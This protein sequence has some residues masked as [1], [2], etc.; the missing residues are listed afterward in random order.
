MWK[1][2]PATKMNVRGKK[3]KKKKREREKR[4]EKTNPIVTKHYKNAKPRRL[5]LKLPKDVKPSLRLPL[6]LLN[7]AFHGL[8]STFRSRPC[9][10]VPG[11]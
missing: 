11:R 5:L 6:F 10:W 9:Q 8:A 1:R 4:K 2:V 3:K 7:I